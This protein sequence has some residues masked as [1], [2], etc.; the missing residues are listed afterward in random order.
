MNM[1]DTNIR[2]IQHKQKGCSAARRGAL[3]ALAALLSLCCALPAQA[4]R[5]METITGGE[6]IEATILWGDL[7][8]IYHEAYTI[9]NPTNHAYDRSVAARW[10]ASDNWISVTND[11]DGVLMAELSAT[12][13][14]D[15]VTWRFLAT[16][17]AQEGSETY[18][19]PPLNPG[20]ASTAY[21]EID[22]TIGAS[23]ET[24]GEILVTIIAK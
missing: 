19:M 11:G 21:F 10:E 2:N 8:F 9:W 13:L 18:E 4:D 7:D 6:Q 23:H 17:D 14:V 22:G 20:D 1:H 5:G 12:A 15:T 16:Q 24:L 3:F